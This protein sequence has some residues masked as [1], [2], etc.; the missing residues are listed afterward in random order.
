M[1]SRRSLFAY[2]LLAVSFAASS[3]SAADFKPY[4]AAAFD[5]AQK[6]GKPILVDI[7]ASWCPTCKA[8]KPILSELTAKPEFKD[9][10]VLEVDFDNQT[11]V[12]RGF[13]ARAQST[14]ITFKGG[15][16]TARTV[17]ETR[18]DAIAAQLNSA[19]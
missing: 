12:V 1:I 15:K 3:A 17:G 4:T 9:M 10:V 18:K 11:D 16:E 2:A 13:N 5:A 6:S 14:L 19:I 8:Q 7:T